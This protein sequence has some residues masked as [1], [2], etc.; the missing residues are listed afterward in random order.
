[1]QDGR[2]RYRA[3]LECLNDQAWDRLGAHVGAGVRH[4]GRELGLDGYRE[5]LAADRR[6]IPDLRYRLDLLLW[7]APLLAARLRFDCTPS[8]RFLGLAVNGRRVSFSENVLYRYA[9]GLIQ[10]VWSVIDKAAIERQL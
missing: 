9:D 1:M 4:N 2:A 3:Y 7:D 10:E 5:M 8:G 6:A